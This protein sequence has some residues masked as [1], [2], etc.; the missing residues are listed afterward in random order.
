MLTNDK[1]SEHLT[2][3][4]GVQQMDLLTYNVITR[5]MQ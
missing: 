4:L 2:R 5:D 1:E 3:T